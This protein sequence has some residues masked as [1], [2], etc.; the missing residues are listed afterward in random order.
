MRTSRPP[1]GATA[2]PADAGQSSV[3]HIG[4]DPSGQAYRTEVRPSR[5]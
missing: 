4:H 3:I 2:T 1:S 5:S